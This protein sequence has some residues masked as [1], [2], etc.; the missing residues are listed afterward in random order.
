MDAETEE[1]ADI[2]AYMKADAE[3]NSDAET[4]ADADKN[5]ELGAVQ[6]AYEQFFQHRLVQKE[7][8]LM[9]QD[10]LFCNRKEKSLPGSHIFHDML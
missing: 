4:N 3:T 10:K 5:A 6:C 8:S 1:D 9:K 7:L 2:D